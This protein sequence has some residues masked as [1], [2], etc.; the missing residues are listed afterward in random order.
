MKNLPVDYFLDADDDLLDFLEKQGEE[1]IKEIEQ[2]NAI[3]R[4]SGYKL[5]SILIVGIGSSFLLLTQDLKSDYMYL[6]LGMFTLYWTVC[7]MY[8]VLRVL[9]VQLRGLISSPPGSLY[10]EVHKTLDND[11]FNYFRDKGF[12][13]EPSTL[14]IIRRIRVRDLSLTA[15]DLLLINDRIRNE[16]ERVRIATILTPALALS[17]SVIQYFFS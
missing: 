12:E 17:L 5:L 14:A 6:G 11:D 1:C 7:A 13:G 3:N 15:E 16:L 8:L 9:S 10:T 2:S 4:E